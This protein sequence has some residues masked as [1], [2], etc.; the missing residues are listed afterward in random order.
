MNED[1][2][3]V[4]TKTSSAEGAAA[5]SHRPAGLNMKEPTDTDHPTG[6]KQAAENAATE[7]PS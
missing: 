1:P 3:S 5:A 2:E 6:H 7:S 4:E